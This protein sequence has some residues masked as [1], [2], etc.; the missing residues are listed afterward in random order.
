MDKIILVSTCTDSKKVS[1]ENAQLRNCN[2]ISDWQEKLN[3]VV[4]PLRPA[5]ALYSG[6]HW[7]KTLATQK[8]LSNLSQITTELWILSAGY[9]LIP[10][11]EPLKSY[12]ATFSSGSDS[13]HK[14][15]WPPEL[16]LSKDRSRDWWNKLQEV[17]PKGTPKSL[18][19]IA[20]SEN[21]LWLVILSEPYMPA[22][23]QDLISL[24]TAGKQLLVISAGSYADRSTLHTA[25]WPNL[26][27]L[28]DKFEMYRS[29][30]HG[31]KVALNASFAHWLVTERL[32]ELLVSPS[33]LL[34]SVEDL[35]SKLPIPTQMDRTDFVQAAVNCGSNLPVIDREKKDSLPEY[36]SKRNRKIKPMTDE[37]VLMF[38]KKYYNSGNGS[39]SGLI[40]I[41]RHDKGRL[42]YDKGRSCEEKRFRK[43]YRAY[44]ERNQ[45]SFFED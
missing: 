16:S 40:D 41:L 39:A 19:E 11:N 13:I 3:K 17:K 6:A 35:E 36:W 20:P 15:E 12:S 31:P 30:L 32:E 38:I 8:I 34:K 21:A 23:E 9:G 43:L 24:V 44:K 29:C 45:L 22:L 18:I 14:L 28:S 7:N 5:R 27:P 10:E 26:F 25:L 37:E 2:S 4:S 42:G 1:S 33:N